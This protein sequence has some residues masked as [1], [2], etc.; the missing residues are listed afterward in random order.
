MRLRV[1]LRGTHNVLIRV[2]VHSTVDRVHNMVRI[3]HSRSEPLIA[4]ALQGN[5]KRASNDMHSNYHPMRRRS[6][7]LPVT[8][9]LSTR[10]K[11]FDIKK[12]F[13][14]YDLDVF[15]DDPRWRRRSA[16]SFLHKH[17]S[18]SEGD[19]RTPMNDSGR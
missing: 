15:L 6:V 8:D 7:C 18:N 17:R 13:N 2:E 3:R 10:V 5:D 4:R 1:L 12:N 19:I 16:R 11:G 14:V 9:N